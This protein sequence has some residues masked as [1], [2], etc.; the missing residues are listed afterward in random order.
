M[1]VKVK[2]DPN[3]FD[4]KPDGFWVGRL[5]YFKNNQLV[6]VNEYAKTITLL[7]TTSSGCNGDFFSDGGYNNQ[8]SRVRRL[9]KNE[10]V[11]LRNE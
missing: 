1:K 11:E 9:N 5:D 4:Q 7:E 3:V 10:Y 2:T 6:L 8:L